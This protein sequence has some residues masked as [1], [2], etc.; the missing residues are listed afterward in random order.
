MAAR[1]EVFISATSVDIGYRRVAKDALQPRL[2]RIPLS[3]RHCNQRGGDTLLP[4]NCS[5]F[6]RGSV[7]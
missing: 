3:P 5:L 1:K 4:M 6:H 7:V 2:A